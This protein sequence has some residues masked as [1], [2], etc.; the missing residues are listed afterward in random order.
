MSCNML[1]IAADAVALG[2]LGLI[3]QIKLKKRSELFVQIYFV[4]K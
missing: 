1:Q 4:Q 2:L 3:F